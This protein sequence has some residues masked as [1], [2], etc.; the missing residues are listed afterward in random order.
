MVYEEPKQAVCGAKT[1]ARTTSDHIGKPEYNG[2][3][4]PSHYDITVTLL[5]CLN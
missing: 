5:G 3:Q 2:K 1:I 4:I